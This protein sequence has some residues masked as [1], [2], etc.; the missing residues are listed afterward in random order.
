MSLKMRINVVNNNEYEDN[1]EYREIIINIPAEA[2]K[3]E[4]D[5]KYLGLDYSNLSFQDTHTVYCEIIDDDDPYFADTMSTVL[6]DIIAQANEL[7]YTTP[8]QDMNAMFN[9]IKNLNSESRYKFLAVLEIKK[10]KLLNMRDAI[11]YA[12]QL[13]CF[14]LHNDINSYEQYG[15]K[16]IDN[17]DLCIEDFI[18][19]INLE[20]L[21]EAYI[22]GNKGIFTEQ[23]LI[24]ERERDD[25]KENIKYYKEEEE[26]FE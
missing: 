6:S 7:K 5:F 9:I 4:R 16:L 20:E 11:K 2:I 17:K 12:N 26:E 14:E 18:D 1:E 25:F 24:F 21:G 22:N 8:F 13:E 15:R 19:Y 3:L 23:G 10:S